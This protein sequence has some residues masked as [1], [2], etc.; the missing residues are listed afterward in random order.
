[1][2]LLLVFPY[3]CLVFALFFKT[4]AI[5]FNLSHFPYTLPFYF[6]NKTLAILFILSHFPYPCFLRR[7]FLSIS[8]ICCLCM[9]VGD[10]SISHSQSRSFPVSYILYT[11]LGQILQMNNTEGFHSSCKMITNN[12]EFT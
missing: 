11:C 12:L 7:Y 9:A 10:R 5:L 2:N 1:M 4:L 6:K 8:T 3:F